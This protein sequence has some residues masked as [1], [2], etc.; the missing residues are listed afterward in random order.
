MYQFL[1]FH[2]MMVNRIVKFSH[3]IIEALGKW[4]A[5]KFFCGELL[6]GYLI[7]AIVS[8]QR[9]YHKSQG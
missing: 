5:H 4:Y 7:Y 8:Y 6:Y 2:I 1:K 3:L 9:N